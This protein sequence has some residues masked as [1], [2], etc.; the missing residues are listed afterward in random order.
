MKKKAIK[1]EQKDLYAQLERETEERQRRLEEKQQE[2]QRSPPHESPLGKNNPFRKISLETEQELP[3][4]PAPVRRRS[5]ESFAS[6]PEDTLIGPLP[7][8]HESKKRIEKSLKRKLTGR[9]PRKSG[10]VIR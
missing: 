9:T 7:G 10:E 8:Q 3:G 2:Q 1:A 5:I 6:E 4:E